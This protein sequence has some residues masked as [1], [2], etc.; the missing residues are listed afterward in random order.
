MKSGLDAFTVAAS[1]THVDASFNRFPELADVPA[2]MKSQIERAQA[3]VFMNNA[4]MLGLA[5]HSQHDAMRRWP[6]D[7]KTPD[8]T[9]ILSWR[10]EVLP[11]LEGTQLFDQIKRDEAWNSTTNQAFVSQM[12]AVFQS[13]STTQE[14][15]TT[16]KLVPDGHASG[17]MILDT[18]KGTDTPW[19][20]PDEFV[21]EGK[22]PE[23]LLGEEPA[24]GYIVVNRDGSV[25]QLPRAALVAKLSGKPAGETPAVGDPTAEPAPAEG[26]LAGQEPRVWTS[27]RSKIKAVLVGAGDGKVTLK[28]IDT[29]REFTVPLERLSQEDQN[30]VRSLNLPQ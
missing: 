13:P 7:V 11:F 29:N 24:G 2:M 8:G 26:P 12:P 17:V 20:K 14:N 9:A 23:T 19:S 28:R 6:A 30:Y 22:A 4:R 25:E 21:L 10:Y 27:G 3:I 18:G 1:G 16:W 15:M 5:A